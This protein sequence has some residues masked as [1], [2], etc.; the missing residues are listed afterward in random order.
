M[1]RNYWI[2]SNLAQRGIV[3]EER[4]LKVDE[5][6]KGHSSDRQKLSLHHSDDKAASEP[7]VQALELVEVD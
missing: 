4:T 7:N 3:L 2:D 1:I 5:K 6:L